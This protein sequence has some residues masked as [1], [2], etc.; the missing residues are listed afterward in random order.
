MKTLTVALWVFL[1][2]YGLIYLYM[3]II[4]GKPFRYIALN[5]FAGW[6]CFAVVELFSFISGL[7]IP[8]NP[9][10]VTV[11]GVFGVPGTVFLLIVRYCIFI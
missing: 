8:V 9:A 3:L 2:I 5:A 11:S 7:H 6:W 1:G 10:T 4:S